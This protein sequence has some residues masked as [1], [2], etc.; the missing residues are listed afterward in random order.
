MFGSVAVYR[1]GTTRLI[2]TTSDVTTLPVEGLTCYASTALTLRSALA[3][4]LITYGGTSIRHES[5]KQAPAQTGSA[6][7]LPAGKLTARYLLAAVTN[8]PRAF[9]TLETIRAS[10]S[11]VLQH[12]VSLK[13]R[14]LA[15]PVLRVRQPLDLDNT[16]FAILSSLLEHINGLTTLEQV[17]LVFDD[18]LVTPPL[19]ARLSEILSVLKDISKLR[20]IAAALR[21]VECVVKQAEQEVAADLS[22]TQKLVRIQLTQQQQILQQI[23][24]SRTLL[25]HT[26]S[27][28]IESEIT[29][30][31]AEISRLTGVLSGPQEKERNI[32]ITVGERG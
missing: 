19:L 15:L 30:C 29:S 31:T 27:H 25:D 13:L 3:N 6:V 18:D 5:A 24:Q 10:I 23:L 8:E 1:F 4:H 11:A 21:D 16:L 7:V 12:T 28:S 9:P 32:A 2:I 22:L 14:S 26:L 20:V 17:F